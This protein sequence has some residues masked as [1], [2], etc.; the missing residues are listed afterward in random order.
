MIYRIIAAPPGYPPDQQ[1]G[2]AAYETLD[3]Q[4]LKYSFNSNDGARYVATVEKAREMIPANAKL[5]SA[6]PD[7]QFLELWGD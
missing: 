4:T 1:Y 6:E 7:F 5:L 3:F 2:A